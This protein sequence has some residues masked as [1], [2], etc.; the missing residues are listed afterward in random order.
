VVVLVVFADAGEIA[1]D[2]DVELGRVSVAPRPERSRM[3]GVPR[4]PAQTTTS[5]FAMTRLCTGL[6][7]LSSS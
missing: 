3:E 7:R 4:A 2:R 5:F 1:N 6:L